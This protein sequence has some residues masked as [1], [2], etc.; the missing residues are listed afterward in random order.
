MIEF[1]FW[2]MSFDVW[3]CI[4]IIFIFVLLMRTNQ[5]IQPYKNPVVNILEEREFMCSI[6]TFYAA[7][8]FM[9]EKITD[10]EKM[11]AFLIVLFIYFRFGLLWM[12]LFLRNVRKPFTLKI[13]ACIQRVATNKSMRE[14]EA[15][16]ELEID[17]SS[18]QLE[19]KVGLNEEEGEEEQKQ[20]IQGKPTVGEIVPSILKMESNALIG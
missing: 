10:T 5:R 13:A 6:S 18:A 2:P 11:L 14:M 17:F 9:E 4:V 15:E 8:L 7:L 20:Q 3:R 19:M 12:Y 1:T 16:F